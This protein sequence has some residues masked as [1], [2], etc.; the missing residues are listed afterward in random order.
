MI[1]DELF[2]FLRELEQN[3]DR[4]W[5]ARNRDRY[6]RCVRG[7][8]LG[9]IADFGPRLAEFAPRFVADPRANGGS[10]F[11]I[12]RDIRFSKDKRPYKTNSGIHFRHELGKD[13][14]APGFYLH[15]APGEVFA[16]MGIWH[17]ETAAAY[18]IRRSIA[19]NPDRWIHI[20]G[21]DDFAESFTFTGDSLSKP[22]QGYP[23][24]HPLITHLKLK[25]FVAT[26]ELTEAD[27]CSPDFPDV[28]ET[29]C[30]AGMPFMSFLAESLG[31]PC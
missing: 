23:P 22:P 17:P 28:Y 19:E 6:E 3:N 7:P 2:D 15:L 8:L 14:H 10:L 13:V 20:V 1:P 5:F 30:R 12:N 24:D 9:F 31:L 4:E 16:G 26:A 25:D 29:L 27:A 18:K 21:D 11:R